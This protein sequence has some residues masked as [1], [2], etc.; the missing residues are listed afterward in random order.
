[1]LSQR[2]CIK[3][4]S[5]PQHSGMIVEPEATV[6]NRG[7]F[8]IRPRLVAAALLAVF[9]VAAIV[10]AFTKDIAVGFDEIA[11]V[12]F[13]AQIQ[14]CACIPPLTDLKLL[15]PDRMQFTSTASYLNHPSGYYLAL[16]LG[17]DI[18]ATLPVYRLVHATMIAAALILLSATIFTAVRDDLYRLAGIVLVGTVPVMAQL[19]G[20]VNNDNLAILG[21]A[22]C[23]FG[24]SRYLNERSFGTLALICG[25]L[26][27]AAIAKLTGLMLC[28][29][30]VVLLF[31]QVR[32]SVRHLAIVVATFSIAVVPYA[33]LWLTYGSPAPDT[34][35]Q[36]QMLAEGARQAGWDQRDRLS[37]TAYLIDFAR[38]MLS[39]WMPRLDTR[40]PLQN[41]ALLL[42][43]A[44]FTVGVL[45]C[46]R[47]SLTRA[48]AGA[49]FLTLAV[50]IVFSYQRHLETGWLLDAY[51]RYYLPMLGIWALGL[52][53][54]LKRAP[55]W[56]AWCAIVAP[57]VFAL[58]G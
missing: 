36:I 1:M 20:S 4:I 19:G 24:A 14:A 3:G 11:H 32:P 37:P 2:L 44:L 55:P 22:F 48:G 16:A 17:P 57:L 50:H 58:L 38:Q 43:L 30:F 21:G 40:T 33:L 41:A 52:A 31:V 39:A 29:A 27:L 26:A 5:L 7:A 13:I 8:A 28:G 49:V 42:P 35:G 53:N 56:L 15:D 25:G 9:L 23:V 54:A 47:D 34:P 10:Q 46:W 51:P 45:G 18:T 12:S 6:I